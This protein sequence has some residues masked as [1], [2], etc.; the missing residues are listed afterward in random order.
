[1]KFEIINYMSEGPCKGT[2]SQARLTPKNISSKR[3]FTALAQAAEDLHTKYESGFSKLFVPLSS[4]TSQDLAPHFT[5]EGKRSLVDRVLRAPETREPSRLRVKEHEGMP[6]YL[7]IK[8]CSQVKGSYVMDVFNFQT[9]I[10]PVEE[11][12]KLTQEYL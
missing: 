2:P 5:Y 4:L 3:L 10:A 7:D 8:K 6:L 9:H 1:M 11:L 12:I